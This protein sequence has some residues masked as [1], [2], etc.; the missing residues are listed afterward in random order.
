MT[1]PAIPEAWPALLTQEQAAVYCGVSADSFRRV[2]TIA[3]RDMGLNVLRWSRSQLDAWIAGLPP[4]LQRA[5]ADEQDAPAEIEPA[6][7]AA[8]E[9]Q[10][11][12]LDKVRARMSGRGKAWPQSD[13]SSGSSGRTAA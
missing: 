8:V 2:C 10:T 3:P 9:R 13:T 6:R 12:A 7:A 1:R 4:R 5:Q 11:D